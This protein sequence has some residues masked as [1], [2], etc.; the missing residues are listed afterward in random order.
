MEIISVGWGVRAAILHVTRTRTPLK[1]T[2][3]PMVHLGE[4]RYYEE[5]SRRLRAHDL[6]VAEGVVSTDKRGRAV[7][8]AYEL[9][10]E[11]VLFLNRKMSPPIPSSASLRSASTSRSS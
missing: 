6:I 11:S 9:P 2:L 10:A 3:Y 5:M 8:L 1:F 7:T 4:A